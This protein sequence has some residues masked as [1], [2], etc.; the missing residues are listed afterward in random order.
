MNDELLDPRAFY[1]AL[2]ANIGEYASRRKVY[3]DAVDELIVG[4]CQ[5]AESMLDIGCGD[6]RRTAHLAERLGVHELELL[7]QSRQMLNLARLNNPRAVQHLADISETGVI[8][9]GNFDLIV[10]LWN[11]LGHVPGARRLVALLNMR[12]VLGPGGRLF[13]D[14]N[15]RY[16][17]QAYGWRRVAG[18]IVRNCFNGRSGEVIV[19]IS[20]ED[21]TF[22]TR[23]HVFTR[24]E[25]RRLFR[26]ADLR[27]INEW[28]VD[29]ETGEL[30]QSQW[31]GQLV[32]ELGRDD[33]G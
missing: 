32:Y 6:A 10:C 8:G 25:M 33:Y 24:C 7:D 12:L 31:A 4:R 27:V 29:Y 3:L 21:W 28:F 1:D 17:A 11:V 16:N 19:S 20:V 5:K 9:N 13:L 2:A 22:R 26:A 30:H 23:S 18:N 14:V 15:N